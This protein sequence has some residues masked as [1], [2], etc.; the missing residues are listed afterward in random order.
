MYVERR[1]RERKTEIDMERT[2]ER[3]GERHTQ[4][5]RGREGET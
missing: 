5:N 1:L 3:E 2:G 4:R